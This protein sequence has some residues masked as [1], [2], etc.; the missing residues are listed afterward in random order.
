MKELLEL[1]QFGEFTLAYKG[2]DNIWMFQFVDSFAES[3]Y[4]ISESLT[5][6]IEAAL[7]FARSNGEAI[8]PARMGL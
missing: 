8:S 5:D 1:S 7:L 4:F 2:I 6:V 3:E